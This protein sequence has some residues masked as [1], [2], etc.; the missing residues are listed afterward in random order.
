MSNQQAIKQ[1]KATRLAIGEG[2]STRLVLI[3][4]ALTFL[5][6]MLI[7]PLLVVFV[8]AFGRGFQVYLDALMLPDT[9]AALQL[10]LL[11]AA[12]AVPLNLVFGIAAAWL[13]AKFDFKGKSFL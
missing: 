2:P 6:V 3:I 13:I 1:K 5:G 12:I 10:T 4:V 8:E 11:V 9:A 7:A